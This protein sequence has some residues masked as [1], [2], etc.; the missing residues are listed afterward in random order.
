MDCL[1][2]EAFAVARH[3][4]V[5]LPF[6]STA[7]YREAFYHKPLPSAYDH[8]PTMLHDLRGRG[9]T[10]IDSLRPHHRDSPSNSARC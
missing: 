9:R 1:N 3:L 6:A 4:C 2:E 10:E 7:E 5:V 8:Y